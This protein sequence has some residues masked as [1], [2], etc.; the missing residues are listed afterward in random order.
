MHVGICGACQTQ[1]AW[2]EWAQLTLPQLGGLGCVCLAV[3]LADLKGLF[4]P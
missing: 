4:Q 3:R 1:P 2:W